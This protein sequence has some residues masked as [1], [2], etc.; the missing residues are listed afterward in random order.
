MSTQGVFVHPSS[1]VNLL[2][3]KRQYGPLRGEIE[4]TLRRFFV[5]FS[6]RAD[7]PMVT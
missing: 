6:C 2:D 4:K 5:I 7:V 1:Y 3:L